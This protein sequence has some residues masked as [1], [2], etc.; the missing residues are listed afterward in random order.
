MTDI[1]IYGK[2]GLGLMNLLIK[3]LQ[4]EIIKQG[5]VTLSGKYYD[6]SILAFPELKDEQILAPTRA[7]GVYAR[8]IDG[9]KPAYLLKLSSFKQVDKGIKIFYSISDI[10]DSS[11]EQLLDLATRRLVGDGKIKKYDR[12]PL[13]SVLD[14]LQ[15][16]SLLNPTANPGYKAVLTLKDRLEFLKEQ[17]HWF[18][19]VDPFRPIEKLSENHPNVWKDPL[20]LRDIAYAARKL[21]ETEDLPMD[22]RYDLFKRDA[23]MNEKRL[24]RADVDALLKRCME[25]EPENPA[26]HSDMGKFHYRNVMELTRRKGRNDQ[27]PII[28]LDKAVDCY[29]MAI[30]LDPNRISDLFDK[31][32]LLTIKYPEIIGDRSGGKISNQEKAIRI[33]DGIESL[34]RLIDI[35]QGYKDYVLKQKELKNAHAAEYI[36]SLFCLGLAYDELVT[37]DWNVVDFYLGY[38]LKKNIAPENDDMENAENALKYF[39]ACW[40][41]ECETGCLPGVKLSECVLPTWVVNGVDKLHHLGLINLKLYG[42]YLD[43]GMQNEAKR[44]IMD[45]EMFLLE[46]LE[47]DPSLLKPKDP[48]A[49]LLAKVFI[50]QGRYDQAL[51]I[52]QKYCNIRRLKGMVANTYVMALIMKKQYSEAEKIL[53][54]AS[55]DRTNKYAMHSSFLLGMMYLE[56]S[57]QEEATDLFKKAVRHKYKDRPQIKDVF[58]IGLAEI[59]ARSGN[60]RS[61]GMYYKKVTGTKKY[62]NYAGVK[63]KDL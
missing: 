52:I 33:N 11:S 6:E 26:H 32:Y 61:A 30:Q 36:Q 54:R 44:S 37:N 8:K 17:E 42:I 25:L 34:K 15:I 23:F 56:Q 16:E 39:V 12:L 62:K 29:H 14:D 49:D 60:K 24:M 21:A 1:C 41:A 53:E 7:V 48:L 58:Y 10:L 47:A 50:T 3:F 40:N 13:W 38:H 46:A 43:A 51:Q 5:N 35:W 2:A 59:E 4:P 31:G 18:K 19:M 20:L 9:G 27:D 57:K 45:A 22:V 63:L 55:I 28:E